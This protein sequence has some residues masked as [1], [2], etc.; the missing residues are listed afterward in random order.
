METLHGVRDE[1]KVAHLADKMEREGSQGPPLVHDG[2]QLLTGVHRYAAARQVALDDIPMIDIADVF[3]EAG[4]DYK[5]IWVDEGEPTITEPA[6]L[7]VIEALP[8]TIRGK[9]GIDIH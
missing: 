8:V 9:Y 6:Y 7:Y 3:A 5:E 1:A 2:D 4:L